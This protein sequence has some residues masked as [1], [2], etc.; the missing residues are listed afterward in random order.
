MEKLLNDLQQLNVSTFK[1]LNQIFG[2]A[3]FDKMMIF[4]DKFGGP[5]VF[6]YHFLFIL[7]IA[8]IML[9][10]KKD[11]K[12]DLKEITILGITAMCTLFLSITIN[13][14]L[15]N[16]FLKGYMST[17]RP[18]CSMDNIYILQEVV[19][20]ISCNRGFP[21]GHMTFSIIMVTSFWLLFNKAF[22]AISIIALIIIAISRISSGAHYPIDL[23][24]ALTLSLPT[25]LYIR[26]K[27]DHYARLYEARWKAFDY[28]YNKITC[29]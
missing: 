15:I 4:A 5:H 9:Y 3:S 22:K 12:T 11:N 14:V 18:Y 24:G 6:H 16:D 10:H 17:S 25:T 13:L 2:K 7:I 21:S 27:T 1:T 29:N 20:K 26:R 28:L 23:L 19:E 8:A